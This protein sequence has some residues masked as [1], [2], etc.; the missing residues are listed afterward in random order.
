MKVTSV[1]RAEVQREEREAADVLRAWQE[2]VGK[3]K[4]AVAEVRKGAVGKEREGVL[5][6]LRVPEIRE[7]MVVRS[8]GVGEGGVKSLRPCA[9]CGLMREERV[10]KVDGEVF[11]G[12]DEWWVENMNMHRSEFRGFHT[13]NV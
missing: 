10:V 8:V 11:D 12:F 13:W 4:G 1:D 9:L 7:E 3:L 5:E 2:E 6:G